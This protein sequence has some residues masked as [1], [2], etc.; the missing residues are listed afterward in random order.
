M[1]DLNDHNSTEQFIMNELTGRAGSWMRPIVMQLWSHNPRFFP[2]EDAIELK[3]Y[4]ATHTLDELR[5]FVEQKA[6]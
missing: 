6:K 5:K 2:S 4:A 3:E 1:L